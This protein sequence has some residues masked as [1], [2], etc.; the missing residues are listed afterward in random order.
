MNSL[1][2]RKQKTRIIIVNFNKFKYQK[3]KD[4]TL[5]MKIIKNNNVM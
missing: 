1:K 3:L 4:I 2:K 5:L